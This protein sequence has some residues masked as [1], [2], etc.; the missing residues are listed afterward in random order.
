[1]KL[2]AELC[3]GTVKVVQSRINCAASKIK[4]SSFN[5]VPIDYYTITIG[6]NTLNDSTK[7]LEIDTNN[8]NFN[9]YYNIGF[10]TNESETQSIF[11]RKLKGEFFEYFC[12]DKFFPFLHNKEEN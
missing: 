7:S 4:Q 9:R 10:Q 8:I 6:R 5:K 3:H 11:R 2:M 1:M 12:S